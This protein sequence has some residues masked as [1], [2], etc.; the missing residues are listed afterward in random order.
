MYCVWYAVLLGKVSL[1]PGVCMQQAVKAGKGSSNRHRRTCSLSILGE[2]LSAL[3][4]TLQH[5]LIISCCRCNPDQAEQMTA[6]GVTV[7]GIL[8]MCSQT[9]NIK[10]LLDCQ[11]IGPDHLS[12]LVLRCLGTSG[13]LRRMLV[14][15]ALHHLDG[16]Q[17]RRTFLLQPC[18]KG[19]EASNLAAGL[20]AE[21]LTDNTGLHMNINRG[22][23]GRMC[24]ML[25]RAAILH[26]QA[27]EFANQQL[28]V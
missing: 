9:G 25:S 20:M 12:M 27:S 4:R 10:L 2:V 8:G 13:G 26:E 1:L 19:Q 22:I 24:L 5:G 15:V 7:A 17:S 18:Y 11:D 6:T 28:L 21:A 3:S 14:Q 16:V 23:L